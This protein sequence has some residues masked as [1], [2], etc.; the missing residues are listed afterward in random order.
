M[1]GSCIES[2]NSTVDL[3]DIEDLND[4]EEVAEECEESANSTLVEVRS[5]KDDSKFD[6]TMSEIDDSE[7]V[8]DDVNVRIGVVKHNKTR[9][10]FTFG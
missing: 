10:S 3:N 1:T 8:N 5:A 2:L 4:T 6:E 9:A 7:V